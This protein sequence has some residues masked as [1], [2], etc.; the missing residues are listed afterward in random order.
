MGV[1]KGWASSSMPWV[2]ECVCAPVYVCACVLFNVLC[3]CAPVYVCA[4]VLCMY[5]VHL[6]ERMCQ[7]NKRNEHV[8]GLSIILPDAMC[9][10]DALLVQDKGQKK[11]KDT[12]HACTPHACTRLRTKE[13]VCPPHMRDLAGE[14]AGFCLQLLRRTSLR[15]VHLAHA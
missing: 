5:C 10:M 3:V 13:D 2:C 11:I 4:C 8:Q 15:E 1:S 9:V 7:L 12:P 14:I 6:S